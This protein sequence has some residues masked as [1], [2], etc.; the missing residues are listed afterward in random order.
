MPKYWGKQ[1]F[2]RGSGSKAKD[3]EKKPPGPKFYSGLQIVPLIL[4]RPKI[5]FDLIVVLLK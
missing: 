3:R 2:T 4:F 1:I 5:D